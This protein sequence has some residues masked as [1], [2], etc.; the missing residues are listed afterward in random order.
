MVWTW[1][2]EAAD[3]SA[4]ALAGGD[5]EFS[6]QGDAETWIGEEW[7]RLLAE[8]IDRVVLLDD[9]TVIYPMSLHEAE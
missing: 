7:Q 2:Y 9:D 4:V 3:G 6:S 8:G 5:E 1:R